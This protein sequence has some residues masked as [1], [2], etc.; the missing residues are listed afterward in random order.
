MEDQAFAKAK[1]CF[2][3]GLVGFCFKTRR[4]ENAY[5]LKRWSKERKFC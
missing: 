4:G 5:R 3:V 2:G 1:K